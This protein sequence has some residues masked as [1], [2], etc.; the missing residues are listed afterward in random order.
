MNHFIQ[1]NLVSPNQHGFV[2]QRS[3]LTQQIEVM[4]NW[5]NTIDNGGAVDVIFLDIKKLTTQYHIGTYYQNLNLML[6]MLKC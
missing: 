5:T 2:P 3:C 4:N 1:N 6:F